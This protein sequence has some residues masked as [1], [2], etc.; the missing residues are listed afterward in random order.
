[1]ISA[2][3]N[4]QYALYAASQ[5]PRKVRRCSR[6]MVCNL[7]VECA[8][9]TSCNSHHHIFVYYRS[10]DT[11]HSRTYYD[12]PAK[13]GHREC[14]SS[15]LCAAAAVVAS[16][17]LGGRFEDGLVSVLIHL[18]NSHRTPKIPIGEFF[19]VC[20]SCYYSEVGRARLA[21]AACRGKGAGPVCVFVSQNATLVV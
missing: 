17:S 4:M 8:S 2:K 1:M 9:L 10:C 15:K 11:Q 5:I 6:S 20:D 14:S 18:C 3:W 21:A 12:N 7:G 13:T 19:L 16:S